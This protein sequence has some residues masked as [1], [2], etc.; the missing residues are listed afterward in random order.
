M[1][2]LSIMEQY[3]TEHILALAIRLCLIPHDFILPSPLP[4]I[5]KT[6]WLDLS[7][8]SS[9]SHHKKGVIVN[10]KSQK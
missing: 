4:T 2:Y 1:C 8:Y 9:W 6:L 10:C 5:L 7:I 3:Q